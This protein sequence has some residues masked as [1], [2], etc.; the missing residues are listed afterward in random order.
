MPCSSRRAITVRK[1]ILILIPILILIH[2]R[3]Q[4]HLLLR[5][6]GGEPDVALLGVPEVPEE[7]R[8]KTVLLDVLVLLGPVDTVTVSLVTKK[9][10]GDEN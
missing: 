7:L 8:V 4:I 10:I 5:L 3:I 1:K 6:G 2:I 9:K